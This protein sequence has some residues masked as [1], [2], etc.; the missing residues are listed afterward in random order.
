MRAEHLKILF[1]DAEAIESLAD[2]ATQ[3]ARAHVPQEI[4]QARAMVRMTALRKPDGGVRGIATGDAFRRLVARTLAKQWA[5]VFDNATRPYQFA[6]QAR[7]GTDALAAHVRV[8]IAQR[9]D[10]V[11]VS[12]NGRS[13]YDCMSRV[14]LPVQTAGCSPGASPIRPHVLC[15]GLQ[16]VGRPRGPQRNPA[17]RGLRAGRRIGPLAVCIGAIPFRRASWSSDARTSDGESGCNC[18]ARRRGLCDLQG[19]PAQQP[20]QSMPAPLALP[21]ELGRARRCRLVVVGIE[22]GGRF[23][24]EAVQLLRLL[25]RHRA[26]SVPAHLR[27]A[28]I[29]SWVARWSGLLAVAAQRAYAATLLELP[30]AAELGEGPMPDLHEVLADAR[31]D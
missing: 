26:D 24:T 20:L 23:G 3:L 1:Q 6:L 30:P 11:L 9:R 10:A 19:R 18:F 17:R 21:T 28:A 7:A 8:A 15:I 13:A 16:L 4:Q 22:T 31:W 12:L 5:D 2:A 27:P 29:T 14:G 25:A